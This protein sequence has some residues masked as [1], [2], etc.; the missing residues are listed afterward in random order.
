MIISTRK[1]SADEPF[2]N[3]I[4]PSAQHVQQQQQSQ[5]QQ[6][7]QQQQ[8]SQQHLVSSKPLTNDDF[9]KLMMTPRSVGSS[10]T[11]SL[12]IS[13]GALM[14]S[15]SKSN[16]Q[17]RRRPVLSSSSSTSPISHQNQ[18]H[19]HKSSK[20]RNLGEASTD[21]DTTSE[22]HDRKRDMYK[23]TKEKEK[24]VLAELATRYRDRAKERRDGANPD[25]AGTSNEEGLTASLVHPS[26]IGLTCDPNAKSEYAKRR[27]QMIE[28]SKFLGGDMEHTHL[29]KGLDYA[30]LQKVTAAAAAA[31]AS[32]EDDDDDDETDGN[33]EEKRKKILDDDDILDEVSSIVSQD[34][35]NVKS[36]L[37]QN[38]LKIVNFKPPERNE[39]FLPRRMA[40]VVDLENE[41]ANDIPI[42]V[43]RS[44]AECPSL[45]PNSAE[46]TNTIVIN[47]LI[48]IIAEKR[49]AVS[50]VND[51]DTLSIK[52]MSM[53]T[54]KTEATT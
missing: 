53:T 12:G 49:S 8:H 20:K 2:A 32:T 47:K 24:D 31:A 45:D 28:E 4:A 19:Q 14:R 3:P 33:V 48:Q 44:K 30:L 40:Y 38:I 13:S 39:L 46:T 26:S 1:M 9:R 17:S 36:I 7:H 35:T 29:V 18:H 10:N 25:Y 41:S 54:I 37:A 51:G 27:R 23:V 22:K 34:D 11:S 52:T 42:T 21:D 43:I 5:S 6:Q 50:R 15:S 16:H